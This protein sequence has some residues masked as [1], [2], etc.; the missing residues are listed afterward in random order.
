MAIDVYVTM[1]IGIN[2]TH[3]AETIAVKMPHPQNAS[4]SVNAK[5]QGIFVAA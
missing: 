1:F 5:Q 3:P 4:L 2:G